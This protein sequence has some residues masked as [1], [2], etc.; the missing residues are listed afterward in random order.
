[1]WYSDLGRKNRCGVGIPKIKS[2]GLRINEEKYQ[3]MTVGMNKKYKRSI[4][5]HIKSPKIV[6]FLKYRIRNN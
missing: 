2:G 3:V 1:M 5:N 6:E 4:T